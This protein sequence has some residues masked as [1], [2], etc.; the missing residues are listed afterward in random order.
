MEERDME[1]N[2]SEINARTGNQH[3][4][5]LADAV[6]M[7]PTPQARWTNNGREQYRNEER[8]S[9]AGWQWWE[10]EPDVGRVAHGIPSRVDRLR[11]LGNAVVPQVAEIV[12]RLIMEAHNEHL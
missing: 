3:S 10:V 9:M 11:G 4:M 8:K 1:Q 5:G 6:Q 7:W 2:G 12:G